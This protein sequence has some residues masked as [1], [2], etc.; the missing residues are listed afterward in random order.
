LPKAKLCPAH[1]SGFARSMIREAN[2]DVFAKLGSWLRHDVWAP[3][4]SFVKGG[5]AQMSIE[6]LNILFQFITKYFDLSKYKEE[7][8]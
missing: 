3:P 1:D 6:I 8:I 4:T 2:H 5:Q 7:T